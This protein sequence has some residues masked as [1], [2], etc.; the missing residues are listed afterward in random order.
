M[1]PKKSL[2]KTFTIKRL[3]FLTST[4]FTVSLFA[5]TSITETIEMLPWL[6][7]AVAD[8]NEIEGGH[9]VYQNYSQMTATSTIGLKSSRI[10]AGYVSYFN[11]W[12]FWV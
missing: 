4:F 3:L 2:N 6:D 5:Q 12:N 9:H 1:K 8:A 11:W 7:L 10:K